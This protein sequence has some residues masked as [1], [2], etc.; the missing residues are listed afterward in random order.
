MKF[1]IEANRRARKWSRQQ[2]VVRM[3]WELAHPLFAWSPRQIWGWRRGLLRI[4]GASIGHNVHIYPSV[5]IAV[6][7]NISIGDNSAIGDHA[8][9]YS[10]GSI[11]VGCNTTVSQYAH[12]CAGTH[13]YE[14]RDLPLVK[15]RISIG[16]AVW[17]CADAFIG[18]GVT[19]SNFAIVGAC[20]VVVKDVA[21]STIVAGNPAK[22]V[23]ERPSFRE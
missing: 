13:D 9:L 6:P 19:V 2:L 5:R 22:V 18:P 14:R 12:L 23:R 10:L 4:F 21:R 16:D 11:A 15:S 3:L 1:D 17:I 20:A 7:W 8:I